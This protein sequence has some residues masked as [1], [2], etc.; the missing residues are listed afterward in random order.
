M[1]NLKNLIRIEQR[2]AVD[3][4][5]EYYNDKEEKKYALVKMPTGTGKTGVMACIPYLISSIN[6]MLIVV[7]NSQLPD[8]MKNEIENDFWVKIGV[9]GIPNNYNVKIL[10]GSKGELGD[11]NKNVYIVTIQALLSIKKRNTN[12]YKLLKEKIDLV[13]FDE[14]HRQPCR[15]WRLLIEELQKKTVLFS[16]TPYRNDTLKFNISEN[17]KYNFSYR[18]AIDKKYIKDLSIYK[19]PS[20]LQENDRIDEFVKY[21][22][23]IYNGKYKIIIRV[24]SSEIIEKIVDKLNKMQDKEI[25]VGFHSKFDNVGTLRKKYSKDLNAQF[26]IFIHENILIEGIDMRDVNK[27]IIYNEFKNSRCFIQQ[28]GRILRKR[29]KM[30]NGNAEVYVSAKSFELYNDQWEKFKEFDDSKSKGNI[31]YF[32]KRFRNNFQLEDDF[33]KYIR[34]NKSASIFK[35]YNFEWKEIHNLIIQNLIDNDVSEYKEKKD[36]ISVNNSKENDSDFYWI[37]CYKIHKN[38]DILY[39]KFYME[40]TLEYCVVVL[41]ED[42]LFYFDSNRFD[43]NIDELSFDIDMIDVSKMQKLLV[44]GSS[45]RSINTSRLNALSSGK[46]SQISKGYNLQDLNNEISDKFLACTCVVG[47]YNNKK[48]YISTSTARINDNDKCSLYDFISW[49][50]EISDSFKCDNVNSYFRRYAQLAYEINNKEDYPTSIL[51]DTT[52]VKSIYYGECEDKKLTFEQLFFEIIHNKFYIVIDGKEIECE[53]KIK[54]K[55]RGVKV[56]IKIEKN[57]FFIKIEEESVEKKIPLE[58][59]INS[60]FKLMFNNNLIYIHGQLYEINP[61]YY[62]IDIENTSLGNR[63]IGVNKL[64]DVDNEKE[65]NYFKDS[66]HKME[67][68]SYWN[69]KSVF[70]VLVDNYLKEHD[71]FTYYV[72]DDLDTEIADFIAINENTNKIALIHAKCKNSK[73]SASAF[74]DVIGQAIKNLPYLSAVNPELNNTYVKKHIKR[75]DGNWNKSKIPRL[76]TKNITGEK[77]WSMYRKILEAPSRKLEV[78]IFGDLMSYKSLKENLKSSNPT[79]ETKQIMWLLS[80][81]DEALSNLGITMKIFCKP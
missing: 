5:N 2:E 26:N 37:I 40:T 12:L 30:D 77:F 16:A 56:E 53:V 13:I 61:N 15:K 68:Y 62:N 70:G 19:F 9:K 24:S 49:T 51:I 47:E 11:I 25:A 50:K 46:I 1:N 34:L 3:V 59:Y 55:K 63:I 32:D 21:A 78:W 74:Q 54:S 66:K 38:S 18:E 33:Y 65:G 48:R 81:T 27:V 36:D 6:N 73:L 69:E 72:C 17:Y 31:Q 64:E 8:Q 35:V 45:I 52:Y 75:W 57:N 20:N 14:G 79:E 76:S 41:R 44:D 23:G 60:N 22:F 39:G 43:L 28:V 29:D 4:I 71:E 7:P 80:T 67:D 10:K 42:M 58:K